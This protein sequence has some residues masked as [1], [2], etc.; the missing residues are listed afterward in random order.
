[1]LNLFLDGTEGSLVF[2]VRVSLFTVE[3]LEVIGVQRHFVTQDVR[4]FALGSCMH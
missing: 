3:L 1:M 2:K 4:L